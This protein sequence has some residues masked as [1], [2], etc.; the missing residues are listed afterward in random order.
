MIDFS[1]VAS[2][3]IRNRLKFHVGIILFSIVMVPG[4]QQTLTP[5]DVES[6]DMDSPE[7]DAE[8]VINDEFSSKEMTLGSE[9]RTAI[10][11]DV[12]WHPRDCID[13]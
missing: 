6:Y 3:A 7:M 9:G 10:R 8:R 11:A 12:K 5:I 1:G 13:I 4:L 2:F